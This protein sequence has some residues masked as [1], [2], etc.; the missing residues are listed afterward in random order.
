MANLLP[1]LLPEVQL[2]TL[3]PFADHRGFFEELYQQERYQKLG[4]Q[5]DFVQDNHSFSKKGTIRGMHF[6]SNPGQSK[7]VSVLFGKII[8]VFVDIRPNSPRFGKWDSVILDS[9]E[10][11]Q[12]YIPNG[13][14]HGF[15]VLSDTVHIIYKVS[16]PF[17]PETEKAF[18]F[19][20]PD[21]GIQWPIES[22]ILSDRDRTAPY[23]KEIIGFKSDSSHSLS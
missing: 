22:P 23:L 21:I 19:D 15:G 18:R 14:A 16:S 13:F 8:D 6:Q 17:N 20:D 4:I 3:S 12:I 2:I 5:E 9:D 1:Q 10:H 7:L 11:K